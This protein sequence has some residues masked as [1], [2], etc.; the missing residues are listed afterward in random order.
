MSKTIENSHPLN[1]SLVN[2]SDKALRKT[3]GAFTL[4][5]SERRALLR[6][7]DLLLLNGAMV[8]WTFLPLARRRELDKSLGN[9]VVW[10][11]V[12]SVIWLV[13]SH[14]FNA[15]QLERAANAVESVWI[16][17]GTLLLTTGL[18][19]LI[20]LVTPSPPVRRSQ[21]LFLPA[22]TIVGVALWRIVYARVFAQ[23][24]FSRTALMVGA[25]K[26]A[27]ALLN[28]LPRTG[29]TPTPATNVGH[30][31]RLLGILDD[32]VE[33][34]GEAIAG[35]PVLGTTERL[36]EIAR[37]Q[38]P[39]ELILAITNAYT[40]QGDLFRGLLDCREMGID[41]TPMLDLYEHVT[42]RVPVAY[43]GQNLHVVLPINQ[44]GSYRFYLFLRR[45]SDF[46]VAL[47]GCTFLALLMPFVWLANR[48][49]DPGDLF[50]RQERVGEGGKPFDV[51]KFRSM[52]MDAEKL[53]GAVW[54]EEDDP[55]ITK[56]GRFLR[57]TRLDEV[58]Q[59]WNVFK[60]DMSFIGPRPERPEFVEQLAEEIPFYR[61]RHAVKP[62]ITGWAQVNYRYGASVED[63]LAKL[64]Y[65]LYYI[66]HQNL[67]LDFQTVLKTIQVIFGMRGR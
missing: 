60:G 56:I 65:D 20:P 3:S 53:T 41:V 15:Y 34:S 8:M 7:F 5:F 63:A 44:S 66:K 58:P 43:A 52:V 21:M 30:G 6:L 48:L 47:L 45:L 10:I 54:A 17:T 25:G 39:D 59:F 62:G 27:E 46:V 23:P 35:V 4:D 2:L 14:L 22:L 1:N 55:R 61:I 57:K 51:I 40:I 32:D 38:Q 37:A 24:T 29:E 64:E 18:Y 42:G 33:K 13:L 49:T 9:Y 50:Y 11:I 26:S 31:Y 36:V 28:V 16:V 12:L 67:F 19:A